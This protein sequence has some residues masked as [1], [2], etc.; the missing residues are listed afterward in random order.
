MENLFIPYELSL[1]AKSKGFDGSCLA[2]YQSKNNLL[3][4]SQLGG[5]LNWSSNSQL[6]NLNSSSAPT[7]HQLMDWFRSCHNIEI[8]ILSNETY[9][10][11]VFLKKVYDYNISLPG[12]HEEVNWSST[13]ISYKT[14]YEA[15]II[16]I[17]NAFK[18]I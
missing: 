18:L 7:Y 13:K 8:E 6:T 2:F 16:A 17:E 4:S 12:T 14:Y 15:L 1:L 9:Q 11:E 10:G 3:I 5:S